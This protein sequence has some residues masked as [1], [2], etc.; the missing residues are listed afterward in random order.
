MKINKVLLHIADLSLMA[1]F[2]IPLINMI[3]PELLGRDMCTSIW[4]YAMALFISSD[5][6]ERLLE[7]YKK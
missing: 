4:E 1:S 6:L 7:K 5:V 3:S 2:T